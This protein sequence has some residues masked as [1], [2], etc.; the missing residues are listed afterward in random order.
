MN[1]LVLGG[2]GKTGR[3]VIEQALAKGYAVTALVRDPTTVT[4]KGV[5]TVAGDATKLEDLTRV[6]QGQDAVLSTIGGPTP[7]KKTNLERTI[8]RNLVET[9][10]RF[11]VQ[12]LQ[13]A[14][15]MGIGDGEDQA[16]FRWRYLLMPT[17]LPGSTIDKRE[18]ERIVAASNLAYTLVRPA[19]LKDGASKGAPAVVSVGDKGSSIFRSDLARF[20][21]GS[22]TEQRFYRQA[23]T[24]VTQ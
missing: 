13:I 8:A 21:V 7:Y 5:R 2:Q 18:V 11:G 4:L 17:F 19:L 22:L 14:T 9:M 10:E 16:P 23:V 24:V 6:M 3:Q 20:M 15:M 1:L 12:L